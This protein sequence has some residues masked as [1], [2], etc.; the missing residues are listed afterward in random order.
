MECRLLEI[1]SSVYEITELLIHAERVGFDRLRDVKGAGG[2]YDLAREVNISEEY[3]VMLVDM[4][5]RRVDDYS[6]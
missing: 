1:H 5:W 4:L 6:N 2:I 3:T